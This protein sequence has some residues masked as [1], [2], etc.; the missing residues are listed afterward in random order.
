MSQWP[1]NTSLLSGFEFLFLVFFLLLNLSGMRE[2]G[3]LV[4][5][6]PYSIGDPTN[7][8]R[9]VKQ[10]SFAAQSTHGR[11]QARTRNGHANFVKTSFNF[12][13]ERRNS[14]PVLELK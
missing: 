5:K 8:K 2:R 11:L 4:L 1:K 3:V 10:R 13:T 7:I 6:N 9:N 12:L 14:Q